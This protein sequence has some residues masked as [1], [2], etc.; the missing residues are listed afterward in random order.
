MK[1]VFINAPTSLKAPPLTWSHDLTLELSVEEQRGHP[2]GCIDNALYRLD[3]EV[4]KNSVGKLEPDRIVIYGGFEQY[5]FIKEYL[6]AFPDAIVMGLPTEPYQPRLD[7]LIEVGAIPPE[8][9]DDL[10]YPAWNFIPIEDYF[11]NSSLPYTLETMAIE[12]RA[13]FK[14]RW[15]DREQSPGYIADALRYLKLHYNFDFMVFEDDLSM[16]KDRTYKL[17]EELEKRDMLGLFGWGCRA[18]IKNIDRNLL[19]AFREARCA[20][21]DFGELDVIDTRDAAIMERT[22]SAV[23]ASR[24]TEIYPI[25]KPTI[26]H[27]DTEREDLMSML[28][29]LKGNKLETRSE[30]LEPYP[31][32]PLF[33]KVK[34]EVE[35]VGKHI[36]Q[37]NE[38]FANFTRWTDEE[39]LGI[40]ELMAHGDLE[41]VERVRRA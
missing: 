3:L 23:N 35:D 40:V 36:L 20:F 22:Q 14:S 32:T 9:P 31:G 13:V 41:R 17:I 1:V 15:G 29:F 18:N 16:N 11:R 30:I 19:T 5:R 26:G 34:H 4:L 37:I 10:P 28:K 39:L 24:A 25:I 8:K 27:P 6:G 38:S 2:V 33:E 7:L 21:V 12:R